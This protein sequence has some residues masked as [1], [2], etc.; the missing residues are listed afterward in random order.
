MFNT[1]FGERCVRCNEKRTKSEYEG[2]PTCE[3]CE[4]TIEAD[5]E[6]KRTCPNCQTLMDKTVVAKVIIDKCPSCG[7]AWLDAGELDLLQKAVESGGN[8][9][10][11][12]MVIG[13]AMG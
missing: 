3:A 13:M 4:L 8:D 2:M 6:E 5:R 11:T 7:G 1:L 9:L 10:A 12:G